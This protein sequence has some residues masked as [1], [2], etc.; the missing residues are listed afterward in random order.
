MT[1]GFRYPSNVLECS[2]YRKGLISLGKSMCGYTSVL[3]GE[4]YAN[5]TMSS[6]FINKF[7]SC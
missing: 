2:P 5:N 3:G 7:C 4:R 1:Y 6:L